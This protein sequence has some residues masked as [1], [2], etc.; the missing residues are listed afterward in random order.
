MQ[1]VRALQLMESLLKETNEAV[2]QNENQAKLEEIQG[3]LKAG[4][5]KKSSGKMGLFTGVRERDLEA[6]LLAMT[7]LD[8][9]STTCYLAEWFRFAF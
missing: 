3:R 8:E 1:I 5:M 9:A 4:A 6:K 2:R 7:V